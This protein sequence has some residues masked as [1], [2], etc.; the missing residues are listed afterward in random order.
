MPNPSHAL[1]PP[2]SPPLHPCYL[3]EGTQAN[4][5]LWDP[6]LCGDTAE[7][8]NII[9]KCMFHHDTHNVNPELQQR[10]DLLPYCRNNHYSI[11]FQDK[12]TLSGCDLVEGG[13]ATRCNKQSKQNMLVNLELKMHNAPAVLFRRFTHNVF[14]CSSCN[15][16]G[17]D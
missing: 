7:R 11:N 3:E 17:V 9:T 14:L 5:L 16:I 10:C 15:G 2:P 12:Y 6:S 4:S 13:D 8:A 1:I